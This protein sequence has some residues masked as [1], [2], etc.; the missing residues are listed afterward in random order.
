MAATDPARWLNGVAPRG[1]ARTHRETAQVL[2]AVVKEQ[3]YVLPAQQLL[4]L[5]QRCEEGLAE[6]HFAFLSYDNLNSLE[7]LKNLYS[8]RMKIEQLRTSLMEGDMQG[9]F[10]VPSSMVEDPTGGFDYVPGLGCAPVDLFYSS[11]GINLEVIKRYSSFIAMAGEE[12]LVQNL[13]WSGKKIMNSL[14]EKLKQ[15]LI[16]KTMGW[17]VIYQTGPVYFKLV[18]MFIEESSPK[19]TRNLINK[20]QAL[21]VKD[22]NGENIRSVTSTIKGAYEVLQNK[23]AVPT[24]FL[25]IV[26]EVL[27]RCSVEKFVMFIRGMKNNHDQRVKVI[28]LAELLNDAEQR[29]IQ[30]EGSDEWLGNNES[31]DS[32]FYGDDEC[33]NCGSKD[34][35]ARDC[36]EPKRQGG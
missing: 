35:Y 28:T 34:H 31:Q 11:E 23:R 10:S 17:S 2:T 21:G 30:L 5:Q 20:L 1:T 9:V 6:P 14:S 19:S 12:Y 7:S 8:V 32:V 13:L 15:K 25:D 26:F 36:P 27:E 4:K 22:Y 18:M 33:W 24:D 29:Y 16:E 3:R